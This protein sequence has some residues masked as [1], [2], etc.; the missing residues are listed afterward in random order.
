MSSHISMG[1]CFD[2]AA[3]LGVFQQAIQV[4]VLCIDMVSK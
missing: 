1:D 2:K 3:K 4:W